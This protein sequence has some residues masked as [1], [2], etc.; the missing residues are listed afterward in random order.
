MK[1][2]TLDILD[3]ITPIYTDYQ[4]LKPDIVRQKEY[5][6]KFSLNNK[7]W[8][9]HYL[10]LQTLTFNWNELKY[11]DVAEK[12]ISL[13]QT[14]PKSTGVYIFIVKSN[15]AIYDLP[16]FVYYVGIAGA[17]GKKRTL[18]ER[19]KDYFADSHLKKRD[20]VRIMIFKHFA[21]VYIGY[22][23]IKLTSKSKITLEQIETSLI[24]FFGTH[25]L[26][27]KDDI[28]VSLKPQAKAFNI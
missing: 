21:N 26:A 22:S 28:P 24:G 20:T 6:S 25:L 9:T 10:E 16:K 1:K 11:S 14:V 8:E 17:G 12:K 15:N 5:T 23:P 13:D 19:L 18:N 2:P 3:A 7:A 27:N 4:D